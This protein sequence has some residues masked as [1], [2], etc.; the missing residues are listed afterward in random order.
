MSNSTFSRILVAVDGSPASLHAL[1]ETCR[2][3]RAEHGSVGAVSVVPPHDGELRLVGVSNA[4]AKMHAPAQKALTDAAKEAESEGVNL[5]TYLV[6]GEPHEAIVSLAEEEEYDLISLGVKGHNVAETVLMG[7]TTA[8]VIGFGQIPVLVIPLESRL[9]WERILVPVDGSASSR[10]AAHLAFHLARAYGS[11]VLVASVAHIPSQLYGISASMVEKMIS[12]SKGNLD[13][14]KS[15]AG[16]LEIDAEY[17]LREGEPEQILIELASQRSNDLIIMGS[18]GRTGLT[19]L[20]MGSVTERVIQG[21]P[22]PVLVVRDYLA[23]HAAG[24]GVVGL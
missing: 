12:E 6:Q 11:Q 15:D 14:I 9:T 4:I 18:H 21:S 22:C 3:V 16:S 23:S 8:R 7:S 2:L 10:T 5:Q 19:R 13:E 1:K 24:V 20:L 17:L